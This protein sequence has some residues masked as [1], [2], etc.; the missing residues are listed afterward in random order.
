M[1]YVICKMKRII[2]KMDNL[3][4]YWF[5][6]KNVWFNP[7][8]SDDEYIGTTFFKEEFFSLYTS[9]NEYQLL[10]NFKKGMTMILL[11]DQV[12]RHYNRILQN[13][14]VSKYTSKIVSF[15]EKFYT[16]YCYSLNPEEFAFTLLP[17][18]HTK[19]Y[20]KILY[21]IKETIIHIKKYPKEL[22][23]KRFLK[24]TLERYISQ[25]DD[26]INIE[27]YMPTQIKQY[28]IIDPTNICELGLEIYRP[29][30][31]EY[32]IPKN[33][34]EQFNFI[35]VNG[36][37][38]KVNGET[39]KI[40]SL[41]GGVDS[42]V[43]SYI[44]TKKYGSENV[45]AVHI[46]YNNRKECDSEVQ[47]IKLWCSF[48]NIKL[49]IRKIV[50]LNRPQ[51]MEL[52]LRDLYESFTRD[53]RYLTYQN[54]ARLIKSES[55][56]VYLGH[57]KDDRFENIFTNIVSESHYS[58]LNGMELKSEQQFKDDTI[59]FVRPMLNIIKSD[60]FKFANYCQ[61][62]HFIDSTPK[63]SQRG[64]IRDSVRP[65][66]ESWNPKA[67]ESFFGLSDA[68][69][70]LM[71]ILDS[72]ADIYVHNIKLE[73]LLKINIKQHHQKILFKSI[74]TKLSYSVSQKGL[75]SFYEK[76]E[77]IKSNF[78]KYKINAQNY[79]QL[80][81][82]TKLQWKKINDEEFVIYF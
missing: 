80:N 70:E 51:C 74:F 29:R 62:P 50:E 43:M 46:N 28:A 2:N 65:A 68:V 40:I 64:K 15:A 10:D 69:S 78:E 25:C 3:I 35:K 61:I 63:W 11:F 54:V 67:I 49:Y 38:M 8:Q 41:S 7:T 71:T 52:E 26:T 31:I 27:E 48:L 6:N 75:E 13:I 19:D 20:T 18:R 1:L 76:I 72:T 23:Y 30:S 44:L 5:T 24:A 14:D 37:T 56:Y 79:Y 34:I 4:D 82:Q 77:Y 73:Q 16:K 32:D 17:L 60:I 42:M 9:K 81:K 66:I 58:N 57:N 45:I 22:E 36:E 21:V 33:F 53:L 47:I 59:T 12:P 39:I 55:C